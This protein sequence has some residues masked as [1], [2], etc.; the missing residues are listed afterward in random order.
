MAMNPADVNPIP[1]L[2]HGTPGDPGRNVW[3]AIL[4]EGFVT[5]RRA[6]D[7]LISHR[8]FRQYL[9][10]FVV[11]GIDCTSNATA[12]GLRHGTRPPY[13]DATPFDVTFDFRGDPFPP[14]TL[15]WSVKAMDDVT[16]LVF[17]TVTFAARLIIVNSLQDGGNSDILTHT[18]CLTL[19]GG[20]D[21][22]AEDVAATFV[23]ELGHALAGLGD[24]YE[25][26][27]TGQGGEPVVPNITRETDPQRI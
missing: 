9:D 12:L 24:E 13:V 22:D 25:K 5:A 19:F 3:I 11:V 18:G 21:E 2:L 15:Q 4:A 10:R 26:R 8:P 1:F 7:R 20:D 14:Q 27:T 6:K 16:A 23:H 17:P